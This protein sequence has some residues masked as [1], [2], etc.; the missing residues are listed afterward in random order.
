LEG[1]STAEKG[2]YASRLLRRTHLSDQAFE[3][4]LERP[5]GFE[6][7]AGQHVR[8][9]TGS[10]GR[11]FSMTNGPSGTTLELC[12]RRGGGVVSSY[13]EGARIG[14]QMAFSGPHG[15]F[16]LGG[17][18]RPIVWAATGVGIA[19]FVSMAR[20]GAAGFTLLHGVRQAGDLFY[21]KQLESAASLY[22]PCLSRESAPG[23]YRGRVTAWAAEHL[24]RGDYDFFLC[25][26]RA[27]I[28]DFL[29]LV[30]DRYPGS[31]AHTEIF[32]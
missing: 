3:I 19:P 12:V 22:V 26:S 5:K 2:R 17:S 24:P 32:F 29:L 11:D 16:A 15:L 30:D 31:L 20:A 21:R 7:T 28:R 10:Q 1:L 18:S 23:C 9:F 6:F 25:G 27:M 13:L 4:E 8:L 14:S